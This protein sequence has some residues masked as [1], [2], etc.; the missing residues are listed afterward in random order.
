[1]IDEMHTPDSSRFWIAAEYESRFQKGEEQKM[2]DKEMPDAIGKTD[3]HVTLITP[4]L[5]LSGMMSNGRASTIFIAEGDRFML[6]PAYHV[7]EMYAAHQGGQALRTMFSAPE[8]KYVKVGQPSTF[9]GLAGSASLHDK[10]LILT[11]VNP[12]VS[13]PKDAEIVVRGAAVK[14]ARAVVL[15]AK[16]IHASNSFEEPDA[17][18]PVEGDVA[19][20]L[21][22][23]YRFSPASVTRLML[24]LT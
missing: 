1:M 23:R 12:D 16:D 2:L 5:A 4:R 7:F 3:S 22:F 10:Q 11:A 20:S 15:T 6:T 13:E 24:N 9:W 8:A 14:S 17:V 21:P 19:V 18:K